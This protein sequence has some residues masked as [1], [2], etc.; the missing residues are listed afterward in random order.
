MTTRPA[1]ALGPVTPRV[2]YADAGRPDWIDGFV[3][4]TFVAMVAGIREPAIA[5]GLIGADAFDRGIRALLRTAEPDG[6]F[7][8]TFFKAVGRRP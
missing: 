8:Y 6:S 1:H 5:A 3:R 4:R 7:G 2:A